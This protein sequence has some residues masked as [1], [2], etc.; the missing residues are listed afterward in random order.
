MA[1]QVIINIRVA[2][3]GLHEIL[4]WIF[5]DIMFR[6]MPM[7]NTTCLLQLPDKF[8]ALHMAISLT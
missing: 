6:P 4:G 8:G 7:E 3:D 5:V 2:R 1:C